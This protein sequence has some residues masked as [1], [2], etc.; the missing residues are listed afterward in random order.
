MIPR[1]GAQS[2]SLRHNACCRPRSGEQI[3]AVGPR[4]ARVELNLGA[5]AAAFEVLVILHSARTRWRTIAELPGLEPEL[6][7][8]ALGRL[9]GVQGAGW[10]I[11]AR[12]DPVKV[13]PFMHWCMTAW[14]A[15]SATP[16]VTGPGIM[17][18]HA[19]YFGNWKQLP[20]DEWLSIYLVG[21]K[22]TVMR[23]SRHVRSQTGAVSQTLLLGGADYIHVCPGTVC[24][25]PRMFQ[26]STGGGTLSV[27]PIPGR[28]PY[29]DPY[30]AHAD[31]GALWAA[32]LFNMPL[33]TCPKEWE[34]K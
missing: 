11:A 34:R 16:A 25:P 21:S 14:A 20:A 26:R 5:H 30:A 27:R 24:R 6:G 31:Y 9:A 8:P 32:G 2:A 33:L 12:I 22:W 19:A 3:S 1:C 18:G 23:R 28:V 7:L 29:L 17:I 10:E 15:L 13:L 4:R